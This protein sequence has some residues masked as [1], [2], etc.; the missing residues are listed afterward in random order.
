MLSGISTLGQATRH[1]SY[2]L[3]HEIIGLDPSA[4]MIKTANRDFFPGVN[5]TSVSSIAHTQFEFRRGSAEDL[6]S[7]GIEDKSVDMVIAGQ[8]SF[9]LFTLIFVRL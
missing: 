3:F 1:L 7:A 9:R 6:K 8:S 5:T 2:A 4:N